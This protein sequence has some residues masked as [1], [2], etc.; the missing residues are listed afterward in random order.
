[1]KGK[2]PILMLAC[3]A[4]APPVI[5]SVMTFASVGCPATQQP[6]N[7][8]TGTSSA[9]ASNQCGFASSHFES[10]AASAQAGYGVLTSS[11]DAFGSGAYVVDAIATS[12][13]SEVVTI[14]GG[15]GT[16]AVTYGFLFT[17]SLIEDGG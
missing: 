15:S 9:Q 6:T 2:N 11:A 17:G 7:S 5:A 12:S 4:A 1:M 10:G 8:Q 16:G 13:F 14:L 3:I